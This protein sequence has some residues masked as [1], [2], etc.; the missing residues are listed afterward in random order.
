MGVAR[1]VLTD[2]VLT[3]VGGLIRPHGRR[4]HGRGGNYRPHGRRPRGRGGGLRVLTDGVLT[5]DWG[6]G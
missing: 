2:G 3:D 1:F 6:R 5:D 4:P